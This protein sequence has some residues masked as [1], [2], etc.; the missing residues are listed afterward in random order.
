MAVAGCDIQ[1]SFIAI[2]CTQSGPMSNITHGKIQIFMRCLR[3]DTGCQKKYFLIRD[4]G[5]MNIFKVLS[6]RSGQGNNPNKF[7]STFCCLIPDNAFSD[8]SRHLR[9]GGLFFGICVAS[10]SINGHSLFW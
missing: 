4:E 2:S 7:L 6:P 10:P 3:L 1:A 8:L 5:L 9:R